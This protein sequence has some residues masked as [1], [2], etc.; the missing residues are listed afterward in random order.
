MSASPLPFSIIFGSTQDKN[1]SQNHMT[2]LGINLLEAEK[3]DFEYLE[4]LYNYL[5]NLCNY[6]CAILCFVNVLKLGLGV[7]G[8]VWPYH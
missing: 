5:E 3:A 2:L 4:N 7:G 1:L 8:W 6:F